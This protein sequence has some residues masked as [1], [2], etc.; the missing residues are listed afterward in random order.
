MH[1]SGGKVFWVERMACCNADVGRPEGL[2]NLKKEAP[3]PGN[4]PRKRVVDI[5]K[6]SSVWIMEDLVGQTNNF[7]SALDNGELWKGFK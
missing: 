1:T 7:H 3:R 4:I 2:R 5:S 6:K